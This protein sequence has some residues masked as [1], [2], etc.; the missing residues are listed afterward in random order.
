MII[1]VTQSSMHAVYLHR[2]WVSFTLIADELVWLEPQPISRQ[3]Y[4][5]SKHSRCRVKHAPTDVKSFDW[6]FVSRVGVSEGCRSARDPPLQ[7]IML[8]GVGALPRCHGPNLLQVVRRRQ[9][10]MKLVIVHDLHSL[11]KHPV[12]DKSMQS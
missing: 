7:C 9:G 8:Y 3:I 11:D 10:N 12:L 6:P 2:S 4:P 1:H 5:G